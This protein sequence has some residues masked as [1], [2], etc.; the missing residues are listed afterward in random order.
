MAGHSFV[1][2][3]ATKPQ[4][5]TRNPEPFACFVRRMS[6]ASYACGLH[7][8]PPPQAVTTQPSDKLGTH[9][10]DILTYGENTLLYALAFESLATVAYGDTSLYVLTY[11]SLATAAMWGH[12]TVCTDIWKPSHNDIW[13]HVIV[14]TDIWKPSHSWHMGTR[15][16]MYWHMKA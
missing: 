5:S 1:K 3:A 6:C 15:H 2:L 13:G 16:C 10:N 11:E 12:V 8:T 4:Q 14:C 7:R 9:A